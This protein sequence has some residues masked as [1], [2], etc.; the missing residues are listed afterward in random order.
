[1]ISSSFFCP[2]GRFLGPASAVRALYSVAATY[3]S[4]FPPYYV[5]WALQP[6]YNNNITSVMTLFVV[7]FPGGKAKK[8]TIASMSNLWRRA[9]CVGKSGRSSKFREKL[10]GRR[11]RQ[12]FF[13]FQIILLGLSSADEQ[14]RPVTHRPGNNFWCACLKM[15]FFFFTANYFIG[16]YNVPKK[17]T[18]AI[19]VQYLAEAASRGAYALDFF[20]SLPQRQ[21]R[22]HHR[23]GHLPPEAGRLQ[24]QISL[25]ARS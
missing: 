7:C 14:C 5:A 18:G 2:R 3:V 16:K 20:R 24:L 9:A 21:P 17:R 23:S 10:A 15:V 4:Y 8:K 19:I 12:G 11:R 22:R 13:Y 25:L 1:M 6:C